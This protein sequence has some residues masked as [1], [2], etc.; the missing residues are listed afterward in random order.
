VNMQQ[1]G[2]VRPW[3]KLQSR[4]FDVGWARVGE[5][6]AA[7]CLRLG[8]WQ[9]ETNPNVRG[10]ADHNCTSVCFVDLK[11][12]TEGRGSIQGG[13]GEATV[14]YRIF[15]YRSLVRLRGDYTARR[16][17]AASFGDNPISALSSSSSSSSSRPIHT[18]AK[19]VRAEA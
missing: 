4:V 2:Q 7:L 12:N 1:S 3:R 19:R 17:H 18:S 8:C 6:G 5:S 14:M 13:P 15:R 16:A 9:K 10:D 11:L